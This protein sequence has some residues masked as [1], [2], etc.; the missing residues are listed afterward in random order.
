[1]CE[2]VR[3]SRLEGFGGGFCAVV[4]H[5]EGCT[6]FH[7]A[8][9]SISRSLSETITGLRLVQQRKRMKLK[10]LEFSRTST[11]VFSFWISTRI[12]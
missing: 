12:L 5:V 3:F 11:V 4:G 7:A 2:V 1:M 6:R 8:T 10:L 9:F